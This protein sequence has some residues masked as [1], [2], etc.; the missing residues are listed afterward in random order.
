MAAKHAPGAAQGGTGKPNGNAKPAAGQKTTNTAPREKVDSKGLGHFHKTLRHNE[1]GEVVEADFKTFYAKTLKRRGTDTDADTFAAIPDGSTAATPT[2]PAVTAAQLT[3]PLSG[4]ASDAL[5]PSP[6]TFTMPPPPAF[7]SVGTA[8]EMTELYWM[9]LLRD[10][11]FDQWNDPK[12]DL[13]AAAREL[14]IAFKKAVNDPTP[15]SEREVKDS[16]LPELKLTP[17][18][19]LPCGDITTGN[20]FRLGYPGDDVGPIVSQF[21]LREIK[22]GTQ[23]IDQRQ[24]PYRRG[25]NYLTSFAE[26][27][28]CQNTGRGFDGSD[29]PTSNEVSPELSLEAPKRYVSCM[30]DLARFVNKDALHQAYFNAALL[31]L[32]SGARW[33]EG[34]PYRRPGRRDAGFGTL[35]GPHILALVSE[36]ATRGLQTVWFQKWQTWLRLRPEAYAGHWHVQEVG[37]PDA[38]P[39]IQS[40]GLP[41]HDTFCPVAAGK[42]KDK[43]GKSLLLPMAFSA[44]SP[45]HPAYG[46]GH[47]TVAGVCVTVLK[48]YFETVV[49]SAADPKKYE[50]VKLSALKN[51][52]TFVPGITDADEGKLTFQQFTEMTIE[53]ELNKLAQNVAMGRTMGGVHWRSDNTRSL[54]LGEALA[55]HVLFKISQDLVEKPTFVFRTFAQDCQTGPKVVTIGPDSTGRTTLKI[56]G[57]AYV[58]EQNG[59][60]LSDLFNPPAMFKVK[61]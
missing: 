30:R 58:L 14:N 12:T 35:G 48:A 28:H 55:A 61:P 37:A 47:A 45:A 2:T 15:S 10:L 43:Y 34:N 51:F 26:W 49:P 56:G 8:A 4:L 41:K 42:L 27:L 17:G 33:T 52:P 59:K 22:F 25:L 24:M 46:A 5:V 20:V 16:D 23:T 6:E 13:P 39:S 19:D 18:I 1:Y 29:Y 40:Y 57:E 21:W 53:G 7:T 36:V 44:G 60:S 50:P 3:N 11:P 38:R 54:I 31:L 32:S 9:A